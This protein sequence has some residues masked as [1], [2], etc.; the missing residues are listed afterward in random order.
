MK[1]A[2]REISRVSK[3]TAQF[4]VVIP[5]LYYLFWFWKKDKGTEQRKF[6]EQLLSLNT[7]KKLFQN[8]N[9]VVDNVFQ[10]KYLLPRNI[11]SGNPLSTA[12]RLI[13]K[14]IWLVMPLI[15][16]YQFIFIMHKKGT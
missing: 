11:L 2:L 15:L 9:F 14:V 4:C 3:K 10:D 1:K 13:L 12:N 16:T 8:N 5:N 6:S 7:W